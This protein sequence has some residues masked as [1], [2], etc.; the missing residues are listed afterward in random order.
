MEQEG[1]ACPPEDH[2]RHG[3]IAG[4]GNICNDCLVLSSILSI[5]FI[6]ISFDATDTLLAFQ[7]ALLSIYCRSSQACHLWLA[8]SAG[9]FPFCVF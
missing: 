4:K 2:T 8:A 7:P 5:F 3:A 6:R 9:I 1:S